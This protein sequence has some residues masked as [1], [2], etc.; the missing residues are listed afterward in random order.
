ME[1]NSP[2]A[3]H[4]IYQTEMFLRSFAQN[5]FHCIKNQE[6]VKILLFV[7]INKVFNYPRNQPDYLRRESWG[8]HRPEEVS[9]C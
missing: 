8:K 9:R 3:I 2:G 7:D 1:I 4:R 6:N 5:I